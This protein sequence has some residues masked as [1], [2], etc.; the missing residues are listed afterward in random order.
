MLTGTEPS[1]L[2]VAKVPSSISTRSCSTALTFSVCAFNTS[3]VAT[4]FA[5]ALIT[6]STKNSGIA[7]KIAGILIS[8]YNLAVSSNIALIVSL[9]VKFTTTA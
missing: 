6:S 5:I 2:M 7:V 9:S 8:P 1:N 4:T 3:T